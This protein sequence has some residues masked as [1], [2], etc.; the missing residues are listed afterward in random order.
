MNYSVEEICLMCIYDCSTR[1]GLISEL[2]DALEY[3][4]EPEMLRLMEQTIEK[5]Y[6]M[7]DEQFSQLPLV[8]AWED[9]NEADRL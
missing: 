2:E 1:S 3:A 9:D 8:P 4:D 7:T 5:L 6:R